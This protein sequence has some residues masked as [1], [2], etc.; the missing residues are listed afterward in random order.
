MKVL[1]LYAGSRSVG[2]VAE[3][4]GLEVFSSDINN[5]E[6]IHYV[7]DILEF[8]YDKVPFKPDIIWASPPCFASN[9]LVLTTRG[10]VEIK[11]V[12]VGDMVLTHKGR[13]RKVLN[14]GRKHSNSLLKLNGHGVDEIRTTNNHPFYVKEKKDLYYT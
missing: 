5:F 13:W 4:F 10:H 1:E 12:R 6:G 11:N 8:D 14:I 2:K 7:V 9:E 3:S